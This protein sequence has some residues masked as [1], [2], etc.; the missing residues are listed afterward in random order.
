M[1]SATNMSMDELKHQYPLLGIPITVKESIAVE[2]MSHCA[3]K[4]FPN[5]KTASKDAEIVQL[6]REAG[7]IP[8]AVTN[9][10]ELCINF[11]TYNKVVGKTRNPYDSRR[12]PGGS[13]GGE[14]RL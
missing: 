9:T 7:G 14:V 13:S 11:E 3:G 8:V 5:K 6:C 2:G 10:P 12:S 1:L 4:V